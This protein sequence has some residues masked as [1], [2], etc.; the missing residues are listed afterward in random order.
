MPFL[1]FK[2]DLDFRP[3]RTTRW[4]GRKEVRIVVVT[5]LITEKNSPHTYR[6]QRKNVMI[7]DFKNNALLLIM[8]RLLMVMVDALQTTPTV[9]CLHV[10]KLILM[11]ATKKFTFFFFPLLKAVSPISFYYAETVL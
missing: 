11:F 2:S 9:P 7:V 4:P 1:P 5:T 6:Q 3:A 8:V 10:A